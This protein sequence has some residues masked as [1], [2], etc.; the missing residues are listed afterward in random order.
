MRAIVNDDNSLTVTIESESFEGRRFTGYP[1][2][3]FGVGAKLDIR[4]DYIEQFWGVKTVTDGTRITCWTRSPS[5][6]PT[7]N[8][9][10][11]IFN[12]PATIVFWA[13]GTKTVVK[14]ADFD[15]FDP[16]KGLAMAICKRV[17]GERFH[18]V[19]KEFLPEED[20]ESEF[21]QIPFKSW[22]NDILKA[23][24][25]V[26]IYFNSNSKEDK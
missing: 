25:N 14:C 2:E 19:F 1:K 23:A 5:P 4:N 13:D 24:N 15:I 6:A 18:S 8:I 17:Y 7:V 22:F 3:L 12:D 21:P 26:N 9:N 10:K 11:V 16:E 20:E